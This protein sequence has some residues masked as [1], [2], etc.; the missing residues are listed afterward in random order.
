MKL[1]KNTEPLYHHCMPLEKVSHGVICP[2][3]EHSDKD[4]INAYRWLEDETG[5]YPLFLAV[6]NTDDDFRI[7]GYD[8]NWRVRTSSWF[9]DGKPG[10]KYRKKGEFPNHVLFSFSEMDGVFTDYMSW[11]IILNGIHWG[12][13]SDYERRLVTKPSWPKSKWLRK[14]KRGEIAGQLV[15]PQIDLRE[16]KKVWCRNKKTK[17]ILETMGFTQVEIKR[18]LLDRS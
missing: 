11:H 7:T 9:R 15:A 3:P 16:A 6:G 10:G 14:I 8:D 1:E 2:K 12:E 18:V 5:F 17:K 4:Y 13:I